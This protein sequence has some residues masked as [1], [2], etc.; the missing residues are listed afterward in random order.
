M[1]DIPEKVSVAGPRIIRVEAPES[2]PAPRPRTG[3]GGAG[4]RDGGPGNRAGGAG[5][6]SRAA[7]I[8]AR[9]N[10][11]RRD[12]TTA[13]RS[14]K[15][16]T[17]SDTPFEPWRAQDLLE[18]N[19]RLERAS[20]FIRSHRRDVHRPGGG[21]RQSG[22]SR[23]DGPIRVAEPI[24]V[25]ELS[26][27]TGVKA[28]EILKRLLLSGTMATI[29]SAIDSEK[30]MDVM[31]HFGVEL[32]IV[33][34]QTMEA[35][36]VS[37]F[38]TRESVDVRPRAPVVTILGHVD[39]G[40]TSLLDRVRNT[41]VAAG[42]AGGI[43][44][45][46]SAFVVP[47]KAGDGTRVV[48]FID[49]PGHEA[50]TG[51]RARGAKVTDIVVLVVA[52]DDGVMPQTVE[53][54][55][56]AKAAGV[57]IVVALN[58]VDK[59]EAT[60]ANI[61]RILGQLAEQ[62]LSPVEWGGGTEVIRTSAVKGSG[63]Q[64]LLDILDYQAELLGLQAGYAG[65]ARGTVLE[66]RTE[67][68]RGAVANLLVQEGT[69]RKGNFIVIGRAYGRV[70]DIVNERG[71]RVDEAPPSTPVTISGI[72]GLP[73][74]GDKFFV[75]ESLK[76]AEEAADERRQAER[77]RELAMP[78][79]TLDNIFEH[80]QKG[81]RKE[82]A[83]VLKTD[84]HGSLET[85]RALVG[86]LSTEEV[87]VSVKHSAI[88]GIT[89]ADVVLA[90]TTGAIVVGFN[91]TTSGKVRQLAEEKGVE[92]RLYEVIYDI[93]DD[94]RKAITGM[95]APVLKLEVLG[96]AEVRSV[97][98][99]SKV[100]AVAGCYVT[101]GVV[102]RNA[103]IRVT[104]DGIVVEKDRRLEQLKRFKDDAKEVRAGQECGMKISGYD[105]IREGDV[106]EC[107]KTIS[108]AREA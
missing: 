13:G 82:L 88:G 93:T 28:T 62:G 108:V 50:F 65:H 78:K 84:V 35:Q 64:D 36:I 98:R 1:L 107:Y 47:V 48:T 69:L 105:D 7:P 11:R 104:R 19:Q 21:P 22:P 63:V 15:A 17:P 16:F 4:G 90:E 49:T 99:I 51:M 86:K 72:D 61:T 37:R 60:E 9:R 106:L 18:R 34:R 76:A 87:T 12:G 24:T 42:E 30:A 25:K 31:L 101:D 97:F 80:L 45:R 96:H 23:P 94:L 75:V 59:P 81:Q 38:E 55:N 70:R 5:A 102:E 67:E 33:Q 29:N 2:L 71:Q 40:K 43:T 58:K 14:G 66:A 85:L 39:H 73:D 8:T 83:L 32:E 95:L 54:I 68:G 74:A 56:H 3:P 53:S 89:E 77:M 79:V 26:E 41:N 46:T 91:V 27:S 100:G 57:P 44:Q 20:G 92:I 10:D 52:A 103:Q 6:G